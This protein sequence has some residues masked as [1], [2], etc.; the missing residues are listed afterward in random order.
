MK[1]LQHTAAT[2]CFHSGTHG[3]IYKLYMYVLQGRSGLSK[4]AMLKKLREAVADIEQMKADLVGHGTG[5]PAKHPSVLGAA[6]QKKKRK[7][8]NMAPLY[9]RVGRRHSRPKQPSEAAP[10][11]Q[12]GDP[13]CWHLLPCC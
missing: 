4:V 13:P 9:P 2:C 5:P 6:S 7:A 11:A 8:L 10:A 1:S 3:T 12:D